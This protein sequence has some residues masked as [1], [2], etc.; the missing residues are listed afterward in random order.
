MA[1][2]R[3]AGP[4]SGLATKSLRGHWTL[5]E[6]GSK[7]RP[8]PETAMG[9]CNDVQGRKAVRSFSAD[10]SRSHSRSDLG[11]FSERERILDVD[12]EIPNGALDLGVAE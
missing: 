8:L 2:I 3:L 4:T 10:R 11:A 9:T 1:V 5:Y 7:E 6:N 12:A